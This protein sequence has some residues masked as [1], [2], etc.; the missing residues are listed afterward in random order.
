MVFFCFRLLDN[1]PPGHDILSSVSVLLVQSCLKINKSV[2]Y[3]VCPRGCVR[4][5]SL[6]V[7]VES[8]HFIIFFLY[9]SNNSSLL[10][11]TL[12]GAATQFLAVKLNDDSDVTCTMSD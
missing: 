5:W 12:V 10:Y 1:V 6:V 7:L 9:I 11:T 3:V 2:P 8:I 4:R